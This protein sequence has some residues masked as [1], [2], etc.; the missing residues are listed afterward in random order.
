GSQAELAAKQAFYNRF[1]IAGAQA[2]RDWLAV[3][4]DDLEALY[5]LGQVY[6]RQEQWD[7]AR[8]MYERT[9]ELLPAHFRARQSLEKLA[10]VSTRPFMD[11]GFEIADAKS[12][13]RSVDRHYTLYYAA[14]RLPVT[15][16]FAVRL[17]QEQA[18]YHFS[19]LDHVRRRTDTAVLEYCAKP[20]FWG[21]AGYS[22]NAYSDGIENS[23]TFFEEANF[24][25]HDMAV[26]TL[27][28]NRRDVI[29][30]S[31]TLRR[32][33][34]KDDYLG[35]LDFTPQRR[36]AL[37]ADYQYSN[38]TDSNNRRA[39]GA[40]LSYW[41]TFEPTSLMFFYRYEQYAFDKRKNDYF[42][43]ACFHYNKL[44]L[45]F[46]Q[47]LNREELFW[48]INETYVSFRYWLIYEPHSQRGH[49]FYADF[50]HDFTS[51]LAAHVE[52][53]RTL[54][55]DQSMYKDQQITGYLRYRF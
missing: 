38:Y 37:G 21:R 28:H 31:R 45:E 6:S 54:Y 53:R 22:Y 5:D 24:R 50:H 18:S 43:P 16:D 36:L 34:Q 10:L 25:P 3:E 27:S 46:R 23:H 41:I 51:R 44:G 17:R 14:L 19:D 49:A 32:D 4:P 40:D 15:Q 47:F 30:N 42:S 9:L 33:L 39:Y 7:K 29:E 13:S 26:V 35:R 2:Y 12:S 52:C 8:P 55:E 48:G 1:D 11:G 20:H